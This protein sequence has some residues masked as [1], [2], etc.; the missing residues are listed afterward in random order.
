MQREG[1]ALTGF[2]D[3]VI[4]SSFCL[5]V[6]PLLVLQSCSKAVLF[7]VIFKTRN[8]FQ[9]PPLSLAGSESLLAF[10][11]QMC[12]IVRSVLCV[13]FS[14]LFFGSSGSECP[15]L[16]CRHQHEEI[17][18]VFFLNLTFGNLGNESPGA[19]D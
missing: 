2:G 5:I 7:Y 6:T 12:T 8:S 1:G 3:L 9:T 15:K 14:C 10:A 17:Q 4:F 18:G 11:L 13:S 16:L 19:V